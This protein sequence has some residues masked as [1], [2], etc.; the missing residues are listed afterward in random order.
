MWLVGSPDH[1]VLPPGLH[2]I[3]VAAAALVPVRLAL[4]AVRWRRAAAARPAARPRTLATVLRPLRRKP[5]YPVRAVKPRSHFGL[6]G[7]PH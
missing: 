3:G 6:R 1:L 4:R 5:A 2:A 7:T